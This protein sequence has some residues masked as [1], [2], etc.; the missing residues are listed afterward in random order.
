MLLSFTLAVLPAIGPA[1]VHPLTSAAAERAPHGVV[2]GQDSGK[3]S[4]TSA[5]VG[6]DTKTLV[7]LTT[8]DRVHLAA[9]YYPPRSKTKRAPAIILLHDAGGQRKGL[10]PMAEYLNKKGFAILLLDLRSHGDSATEKMD[11]SKLDERGRST[12]WAF[13][14]RDMAAAAKF[15]RG[16]KGV[17]TANLTVIGLGAGSSLALRHAQDD[18]NV[19][20]TVLLNPPQKALGLK[21][22]NAL[23]DLGGLPTLI[24]SPKE[25]RE[26]HSGLQSQCHEENDG[27]KYVDL[28]SLKSSAKDML[29]DKRLNNGVYTWLKANV[30]SSKE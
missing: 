15:L 10:Q 1:P 3:E 16:Q 29:A 6:D 27:L 4:S 2:A 18:E 9:N 5:L 8:S 17:H 25:C 14:S 21:M 13:A 19:R 7:R 12:Q 28:Q 26:D 30:L 23:V 22:A 11:W 24:V 20:A